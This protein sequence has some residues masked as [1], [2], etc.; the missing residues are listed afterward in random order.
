M[1]LGDASVRNHTFY[2]S[3]LLFI[4]FIKNQQAIDSTGI[5]QNIYMFKFYWTENVK[6]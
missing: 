3:S 1:S 2:K 5:L 6:S 4:A